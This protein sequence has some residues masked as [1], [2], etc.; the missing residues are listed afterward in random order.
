MQSDQDRAIVE[1]EIVTEQD[2]G[3]ALAS[4]EVY[5]ED[6]ASSAYMDAGNTNATGWGTGTLM[7]PRMSLSLAAS[8]PLLTPRGASM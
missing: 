7:L 1:P 4:D 3:F 5:T 6:F 8:V 2:R